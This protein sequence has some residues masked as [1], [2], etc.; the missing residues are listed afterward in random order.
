[1]I[2]VHYNDRDDHARLSLYN[3]A[4]NNFY[5]IRKKWMPLFPVLKGVKILYIVH[6]YCHLSESYI[7]WEMEYFLQIGAIV[8]V[9]TD[10]PHPV[11][12]VPHNI[13][14]YSNLRE[15]ISQFCP[16][17]IHIHWM[18]VAM[19][20]KR[21]LMESHIPITVRVH[22]FDW[23]PRMAQHL[24]Q[25]IP[26]LRHI[27]V[28]RPDMIL[29]RCRMTAIRVG[30]NPRL[31]YPDVIPRHNHRSVIRAV[32]GLPNKD[33]EFFLDLADS[34]AD[35]FDFTLC[36]IHCNHMQMYTDQIAQTS[37]RCRILVDIPR[38]TVSELMRS[39][40][41]FLHTNSDIII[42][43]PI[44]IIEAMACGCYILTRNHPVLMDIVRDCGKSYSCMEE[45]ISMLRETQTWT[46]I[47]WEEARSRSIDRAYIDFLPERT[48]EYVA[49]A[50][51]AG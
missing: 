7:D 48:F 18:T 46:D 39:S 14:V 22:G 21:I 16:H 3:P 26:R 31:H 28:Y 42:G 51:M 15:A 37:T 25:V 5:R 12:P 23:D 11:T 49:R 50:I 13:K 38:E 2:G 41:I 43:Q 19:I 20:H 34:L 8:E 9:Y 45:A 24:L 33:I 10:N 47:Q 35:E 4:M 27:F 32:A 17:H 44:S 29:D 40:G 36:I 1:M 6:H 30:M